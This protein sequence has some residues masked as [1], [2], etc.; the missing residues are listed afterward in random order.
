MKF[1]IFVCCILSA[2]AQSLRYSINWPSGLS[3]GEAS[4]DTSRTHDSAAP[5]GPEKWS[6][7]LDIDASVPGFPVRDHYQA[8]A[9]PDLCSTQFEKKFVHGSHKTEEH[10]TFDQEKNTA[11]RETQGGGKS[12]LSLSACARDALTFLQ[13]ARN[14][15]AQGRL[16]PQQQIVFGSVYQIRIEFTGSQTVKIADQ[17]TDSDRILATIKGPSSNLT[18]ELFFARD[19]ARTPLLAKV[20]LSLGTFTVE[21]VR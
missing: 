20:P 19:A 2:S 15:L 6:F 4:L 11:T 18:V 13:F 9:S 5:K 17:N 12:D 10:I 7:A 16:A 21:L 3:L 14:E 1:L 8:S